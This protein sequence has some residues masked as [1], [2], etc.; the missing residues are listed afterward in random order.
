MEKQPAARGLNDAHRKMEGGLE[1]GLHHFHKGV[2]GRGAPYTANELI[3]NSRLSQG[4]DW[5]DCYQDTYMQSPDSYHYATYQG[6][7]V[8]RQELVE[9]MKKNLSDFSDRRVPD[10]L[11]TMGR[12]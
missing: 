10:I 4:L 2:D 8:S 7:A 11:R 12:I 5:L 3:F 6:V 9:I 1:F